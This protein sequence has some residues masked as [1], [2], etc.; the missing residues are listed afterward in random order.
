MGHAFGY[1]CYKYIS[2]NLRMA[3]GRKLFVPVENGK[4]AFLPK[5]RCTQQE[6]ELVLAAAE[7]H[8]VPYAAFVLALG[9]QGVGKGVSA[10][11]VILKLSQLAQQQKELARASGER[12][13]EYRALLKQIENTI[14]EIGQGRTTFD[15]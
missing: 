12:T 14:Y 11:R 7:K 10:D 2:Y 9:D 5:I 6:R 8:G 13:E 4:T 15:S 1:E 3:K